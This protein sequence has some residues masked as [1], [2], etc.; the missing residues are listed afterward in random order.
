MTFQHFLPF[1][2]GLGTCGSSA[3]TGCGKPQESPRIGRHTGTSRCVAFG[4]PV[5]LTEVG[6]FVPSRNFSFLE[7]FGM[8]VAADNDDP[9]TEK[10]SIAYANSVVI[11]THFGVSFSQAIR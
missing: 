5:V 11:F 10:L 2:T 4:R 9:F 3:V 8:F 1:W 7:I 6:M